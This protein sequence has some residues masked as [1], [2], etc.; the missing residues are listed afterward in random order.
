MGIRA[1]PRPD[2]Q[3]CLSYRGTESGLQVRS[4][5]PLTRTI[6]PAR[7]VLGIARVPGDKSISHRYAMLGAIAQERTEIHNFA[8]AADCHSTLDCLR[9]LGVKVEVDGEKVALEGRGLRGLEQPGQKLDA[10]N[11]GTTLRLLSGLLAG[12]P[13]EA[14]IGG[15]RSL[16]RRPMRRVLDPLRQMGARIEAREDNFAPLRIHGGPL[17]GIQYSTPVASA[18][19]KSAVLLAGLTAEGATVV[20]EDIQ[21]RDHTE[22]ALREFGARVIPLPKGCRVHGG[23]ELHGRTLAVPGDIS[24]AVFFLVAALLFPESN[25]TIPNVG[26]N[27]TR[28]AV[29]DFL[30]SL[31]AD[32]SISNVESL[33]GELVGDLH[34]RGGRRIH[35]GVIDRG[36][37]P[38]LI[39]ELPALAVLGAFTEQGMS[40]SGAEELRVKESDRIATVAENLRRMGAQVAERPDGLEVAGGQRLHGARLDSSGDHRVAMAF[41]VAALAAEGDTVIEGAECADVSFPGFYE[42]LEG[43]AE[44]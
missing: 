1:R 14:E 37:V 34:A 28:T 13:L 35:G 17:R 18:Q 2:R 6:Q 43:I 11:S 21:T 31:G 36:M 12:Q 24:S 29:L 30:T 23:H 3:E 25:L 9:R 10:G 41:S 5:K 39:D 22:L 27:P 33:G 15:D 26:L 38:A 20:E 8:S 4:P 40:I 42:V 19:V 44:R 32:V 7:N 16:E